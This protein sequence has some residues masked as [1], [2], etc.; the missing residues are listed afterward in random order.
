MQESWELQMAAG[1]GCRERRTLAAP[2]PAGG[3]ASQPFSPNLPIPLSPDPG[4]K[5][6]AEAWERGFYPA[7]QQAGPHPQPTSQPAPI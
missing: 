5:G 3:N 4:G 7:T 2:S 6:K 1:R